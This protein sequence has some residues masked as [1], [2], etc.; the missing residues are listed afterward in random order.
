M[1]RQ[2]NFLIISAAA[3]LSA[4]ATAPDRL[5][6][7]VRRLT[8]VTA[9]SVPKA[10]VEAVIDPIG[11]MRMMG[12]G[13]RPRLLVGTLPSGLA[14]RL[15]I[16]PGSTVLGGIES[17]GFGLA[18]IHSPMSEDSLNAGYAREE[19]RMGW[20]LPPARTTAAPV[21]GFV[22]PPT[23][24][25]VGTGVVE[26]GVFCSGGTTLSISVAPVDPLMR[27]IRATAMNLSDARCQPSPA[28]GPSRTILSSRPQYPTLVNPPGT[29]TGY[30]PCLNWNS[31]GGG[32]QT[33][34]QTAMTADDVL[35]HYGKQ[36]TDSGWTP[37]PDQSISR[38]WSHRDT[39]GTTTELTLTTRLAPASPGCVEV[40][41]EVRSR[42]PN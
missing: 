28:V 10:L 40:Q 41:M 4:T 27:E 15:W 3:F 1:M 14:Q 12:G 35:Q 36:L 19:P 31:M 9:D 42:R 29:G 21:M 18:I 6:A 20:T 7:Q 37:G 30:A 16:P 22:Q 2:S 24:L 11:A 32:G 17:S 13:A 39:S 33:R 23:T 8:D 25:A 34:L 38:S 26:G 5:G